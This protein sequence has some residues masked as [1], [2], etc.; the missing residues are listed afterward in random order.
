MLFARH[1]RE[2]IRR[3][4]I[5]CSVRIWTRPHVKAGGRYPVDDGHVVVDSIAPIEMSDIT[6]DLARE[7]GFDSV[8]DL[9]RIARHGRGD[10]AYLIW[11]HYLPP[12]GSDTQDR[13]IE[14]RRT[15]QE[16]P[17]KAS[18]GKDRNASP[19]AQVRAYIGAQPP[20]ARRALRRLREHIRAAAPGATEHFSYGIPG[21]KLDG[22]PLVWYAGFKEHT[23]LYPMTAAV[24]RAHAD[25]IKDYQTSK[26]TIRFPLGRQPSSALVKKLVKARIAELRASRPRP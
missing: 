11:F 5:R 21:F 25:A 8:G 20:V 17:M 12:G 6:E 13:D 19:G 3:G 18:P 14:E 23:S 2:R 1:L 15:L 22:K 10:Q 16:L 7:S 4:R 9:L 24:R 26:G